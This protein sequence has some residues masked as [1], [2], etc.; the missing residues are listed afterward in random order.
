MA[1][2]DT[3]RQVTSVQVHFLLQ[4]GE[5][6]VVEGLQLGREEQ[7]S[8]VKP[9]KGPHAETRNFLTPSIF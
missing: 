9:R 2:S 8:E 6:L 4:L 5:E 7:R 3:H 1:R